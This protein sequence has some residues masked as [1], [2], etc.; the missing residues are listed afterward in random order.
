MGNKLSKKKQNTFKVRITRKQLL[1]YIITYLYCMVLLLFVAS[2]NKKNS[3]KSNDE[4][5]VYFH[6]NACESCDINNE[7]KNLFINK[8]S[9]IENPE[10]LNIM[11][12]NIIKEPEK[13]RS[14]LSTLGLDKK[15][16]KLPMLIIGDS[17]LLGTDEINIR[18]NAVYQKEILKNE[19]VVTYYYRDDCSHCIKIKDFINEQ[20]NKFS[21][22]WDMVNTANPYEKQKFLHY[23]E[24]YKIPKDKRVVPFILISDKYIS[25]SDSI[26][27]RL[28]DVLSEF[29]HEKNKN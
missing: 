12:F 15:N 22:P 11:E 16:A 25:G 20:Q 9:E 26:K 1:H 23:L 4:K 17:L 3:E 29:Q 10:N 28:V 14:R 19:N 2:C 8:I 13:Y 27:D 5:I 21:L 6:D 7:L 24:L 18:L